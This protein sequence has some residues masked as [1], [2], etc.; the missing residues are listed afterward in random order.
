M[1]YV[2]VCA[3]QQDSGVS[4]CVEREVVWGQTEVATSI[5]RAAVCKCVCFNMTG[6]C[7]MSQ[8]VYIVFVL[9]RSLRGSRCCVKQ[10][11]SNNKSSLII[12]CEGCVFLLGKIVLHL[13]IFFL[14]NSSVPACVYMFI[15][16]STA[17]CR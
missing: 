17:T 6:H 9:C 10:Q 14:H 2:C 8:I 11:H 15:F 3:L 16:A 12:V 13:C 5:I 4:V 7:V 1:R